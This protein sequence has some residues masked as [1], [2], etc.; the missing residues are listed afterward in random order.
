MQKVLNRKLVATFDLN[1]IKYLRLTSLGNS[2]AS[3]YSWV[4]STKPLLFRNESIEDI[5]ND[6][7]IGLERY[8]FARAQN[9]NDEHIYQWLVTNIKESEII[10]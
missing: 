3:R 5:F 7:G 2:I 4:R 10:K 1:G 9:N 8:H 6:N